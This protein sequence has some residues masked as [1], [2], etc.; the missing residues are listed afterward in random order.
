MC[1]GAPLT[2][3]PLLVGLCLS[4]ARG[5][6]GDLEAALRSSYSEAGTVTSHSLAVTGLDHPVQYLQAGPAGATRLVVLLHGMAFSAST[7]KYI[8]AMDRLANA[9]MR[10]VALDLPQYSGPYSSEAVRNRLLR[11][12]LSA[13]GWHHKV[14]VCAASMGGTVGFP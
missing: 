1:R 5:G 12:F 13:L 6:V 11:D 2:P 9:G 14:V 10:A 4:H 8:G 7:W 3:L